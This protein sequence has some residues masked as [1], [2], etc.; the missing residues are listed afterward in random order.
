[1]TGGLESPV[2]GVVLITVDSFRS[3]ALDPAVAPTMTRLA[4]RGTVFE[5][6]FA[7]GNWTPFAF[8]SIL[9]GGAVFSDSVGVAL[10]EAPTL[11]EV[12]SRSGVTTA[13]FNAAN[14][15]LTEQWGYDRGFDRFES[16]VGER[17]SRLSTF[18]ATHP[19]VDGWAQLAASPF[20][21]V[22]KAVGDGDAEPFVDVSRLVAV[23]RRA[24]A[25]LEEVD[26]P[27]F[28]WVHYMDTHT[29]YVPAP[30]HLQEV[31]TAGTNLL[32]RLRSQVFA[33]LGWSIDEATL[34]A[35][36]TL[37]LGTVNQ[38]DASVGRLLGRLDD[39]GLADSTATVLTGDHGEEFQDHG[40][41]AHYP[42]L[43]GE[44]VNVPFL[45][46]HPAAKPRRVTEP[47]GHETIPPT[48]CEAVGVPSAD[49]EARSLLST[50]RGDA[51]PDREPVTSVAIRGKRVTQQ[52]IP[53]RVG[54]GEVLAS[55]RT[56]RYTYIYHSDSG[57]R[58][59]YDRRDDPGEHRDRYGAGRVPRGVVE[60]L[61]RAVER[62][63]DAIADDDGDGRESEPPSTPASS[64]CRR[65]EALGYR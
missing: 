36:R 18:L 38:V 39:A 46:D 52:P 47:V 55:A 65:L 19:T 41:L 59:L 5:N 17:S 33:G 13:G 58:E 8:P 64:V 1:M 16:F 32:N 43:Y 42:K 34:S 11:A 51:T 23:E 29:P 31:G 54:D 2:D 25:F 49:F 24:K 3:D 50:V 48:V 37:Y 26:P 7:H 6:G 9:G 44:L 4:E 27:F 61:H 63:I 21:R 14:G 20:R 12:L 60:R 56:E 22:L 30:E 28:L 15:F 40:H 53:R 62:R 35:L 57:R 45:V 10:P